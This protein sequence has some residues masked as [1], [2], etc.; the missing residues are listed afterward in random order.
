[1]EEREFMKAWNL[2][3]HQNPIH[4]DADTASACVNFARRHAKELVS[5]A[6]PFRRCFVAHL[7]NLWRF[8]LLTPQQMNHALATAH[9]VGGLGATSRA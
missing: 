7:A 6:S 2:H 1:M 5:D 9:N 3:V 4:A 8:R